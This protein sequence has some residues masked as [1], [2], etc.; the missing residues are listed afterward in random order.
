MKLI[1]CVCIPF[2]LCVCLFYTWCTPC[3]QVDEVVEQA[4]RCAQCFAS[5]VE[6]T[7]KHKTRNQLL[8]TALKNGGAF[9]DVLVKNVCFWQAYYTAYGKPFQSLLKTVQKGTKIMQ[10]WS[11]GWAAVC[12]V[13]ELTNSSECFSH[14]IV[15]TSVCCAHRTFMCMCPPSQHAGDMR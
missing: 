8:G 7:R 14:L 12:V 10:V 13:C 1:V 5:L 2:S 3:T 15:L 9:I 6:L 11:G 4:Q